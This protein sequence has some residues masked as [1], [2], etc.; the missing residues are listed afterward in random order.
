MD[1]K[2]PAIIRLTMLPLML[3][4]CGRFCWSSISRLAA[5]WACVGRSY[6][7]FRL[8]WVEVR[9]GALS[10]RPAWQGL[11]PAV[12]QTPAAAWLAT[13]V[14]W[15]FPHMILRLFWAA[16]TGSCWVCRCPSRASSRWWRFAGGPPAVDH[17]AGSDSACG[18]VRRL[19]GC[20]GGGAFRPAVRLVGA[21]LLL[22]DAE[23]NA[24]QAVL[25]VDRKW[26]VNGVPDPAAEGRAERAVGKQ[27]LLSRL[28]SGGRKAELERDE[29]GPS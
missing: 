16:M 18:G 19:P 2:T 17:R 12:W 24:A 11:P 9:C 25:G 6:G 1:P 4:P 26:L 5:A 29:G 28:M 21:R 22:A 20:Y 10:L 23:A 3:M 8:L 14:A 13:M 27:S 7:L 15:R